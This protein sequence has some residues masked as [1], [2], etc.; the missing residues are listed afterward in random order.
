M[1]KVLFLHCVVIEYLKLSFLK[2]QN[3]AA[4]RNYHA[5]PEYD[6]ADVT[7][8]CIPTQPDSTRDNL[9]RST[10]YIVEVIGFGRSLSCPNATKVSNQLAANQ[11]LASPLLRTQTGVSRPEQ[12]HRQLG[13]HVLRPGLVVQLPHPSYFPAICKG[14]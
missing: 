3:D 7:Y 13:G 6:C 2:S 11:Q 8:L 1:I 9:V 5:T 4:T 12:K 14:K 10:E